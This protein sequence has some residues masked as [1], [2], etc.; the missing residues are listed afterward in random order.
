MLFKKN[1]LEGKIYIKI[2]NLYSWII[3]LLLLF[4]H[5]SDTD[6]ERNL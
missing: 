2:I 1:Y 5:F 3:Y 4:T 6:G